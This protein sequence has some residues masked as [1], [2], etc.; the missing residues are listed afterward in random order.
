MSSIYD[1]VISEESYERF[2]NLFKGLNRQ[3]QQHQVLA[4]IRAR[5]VAQSQINE[6]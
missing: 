3:H 1:G 5:E 2:M 4:G 6:R